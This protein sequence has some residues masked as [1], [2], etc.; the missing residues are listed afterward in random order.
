MSTR[1]RIFPTLLLAGLLTLSCTAPAGPPAASQ[2]PQGPTGTLNVG[3]ALVGPFTCQPRLTEPAVAGRAISASG[4]YETLVSTDA[5]GNYV[6]VLAESWSVAADQHTW[7]FK[8]RQGVQFHKGFGELT[9]DDVVYSFTQHAAQGSLNA[10]AGNFRRLFKTITAADKYTVVIDTGTPQIDLL[11]FLRGPIAGQAYVISKKQVD[12]VGEAALA[13]VGCA[14]T[15]PWEFAEAKS[16]QFWRFTAVK[17]HY[18]K[19]PEFQELVLWEIPEE[20]T[21]IANF[22]TGK[23]DTMLASP[24]SLKALAAAGTKLLTPGGGVD[25]HLGVYGNYYVKKWPGYDPTLP[26]VS[27]NAD[28]NSSEWK[29]AVKVRQ[30]MAVS[31]DRDTI[32]RTLLNGAGAPAVLWGWGPSKDRLDPDMKW[33]FDPAKAKSLLVEAGYP[34][35]FDVTLNVRIAGSPAEVQVCEAIASMWGNIG[36]RVKFENRPNDAIRTALVDRSYNGIVCQAVGD[37]PE[38]I[39]QYVNWAISTAGFSGGIEHP[40]LDDLIGKAAATLDVNTRWA[41]QKQIARFTFDNAL[42]IGLYNAFV[43]WPLG[44]KIEDWSKD[45]RFGDARILSSLE[46]VKHKQ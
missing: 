15:G 19:T 27:P 37:V 8:L 32:V 44:P 13:T 4:A 39:N 33:T 1:L 17:N 6:P 26:W 46:Y 31:I 16:A 41:I 30:A 3:L 12:Q 18:R 25:M 40:V 29:R 45:W 24:D 7:T 9:A 14:G 10:N 43:Q 36:L 23:V 21:R 38:P 42:D 34:N 28:M 22:Q 20:A 11:F 35:G 2:A 5:K